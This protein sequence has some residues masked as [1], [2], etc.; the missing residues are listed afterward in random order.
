[1]LSGLLA[2]LLG[3]PGNA[4]P[5]EELIRR[6]Q[7]M[8]TRDVVMPIEEIRLAAQLA[9]LPDKDTTIS[10]LLSRLFD[11]G[12]FHVR[13]VAI[14]ATR[15]IGRFQHPGLVDAFVNRLSDRHPWVRYDAAWALKDSKSARPDVVRGLELLSDNLRMA[16][17][18][19]QAVGTSD[20]SLRAR[21]MATVA[22][23]AIRGGQEPGQ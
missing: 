9:E 7:A 19:R 22:L 18:E 15:R 10:A 14:N 11:H 13:R 16:P 21:L 8:A 6:T 5:L 4:Q 20:P 12:N 17:S 2:A 23:E 3:M 1:M